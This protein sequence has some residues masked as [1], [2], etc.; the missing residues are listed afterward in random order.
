MAKLGGIPGVVGVKSVFI[1]NETAYIVMDF[2]EGETLQQ[3]MQREGPMDYGSCIR[4]MTPIMQSLAE[5]HKHGIIHRDISPD[6][7]MVRSRTA[8]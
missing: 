2:I 7:I 5:V 4:L 3:K 6:N 1:Q 8:G